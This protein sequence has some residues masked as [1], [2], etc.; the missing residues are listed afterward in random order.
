MWS[1]S[2]QWSESKETSLSLFLTSGSDSKKEAF[3][4][5]GLVPN[6]DATPAQPKTE[7][8]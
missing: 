8:V 7:F 1:S 5:S 4:R 6:P 3:L 2:N